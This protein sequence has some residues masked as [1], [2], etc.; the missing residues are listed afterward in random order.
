MLLKCLALGVVLAA[1]RGIYN[2][3]VT[4]HPTVTTS[5]AVST[6]TTLETI[7]TTTTTAQPQ[8][9]WEIGVCV[10]QS[11]RGAEFV[12][13]TRCD[14]PNLGRVVAEVSEESQCPWNADSTVQSAAT[15]ISPS[16]IFCIDDNP[17]TTSR[18]LPPSTT[19]T[20]DLSFLNTTTSRANTSSSGCDPNYSP[21]V[22]IAS[23]VDCAGGSGNGPAYVRGPV[24]VIGRDI[25]G[26]DRDGNGLGCE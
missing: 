4:H 25:Y 17:T 20:V 11:S 7:W 12:R 15:L 6:S 22:P 5:T 23:D 3:V 16:T 14:E 2:N 24:R 9:K 18:Y 1:T 21:C 10:V 13:P 8:S 26:L 19:T